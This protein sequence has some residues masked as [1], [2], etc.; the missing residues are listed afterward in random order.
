V[1]DTPYNAYW[2]SEGNSIVVVGKQ[3]LDGQLIRH[4]MLHAL[5]GAKHPRGY[6]LEKCGGVVACQ[7]DCLAEGGEAVGPPSYAPVLPSREL[8]VS[9]NVVP[10]AGAMATDSGW[11]AI[12]VSAQNP[13][14][15]AAWIN[16]V[17]VAPNENAAATFGYTFE[18]V[19]ECGGSSVY[20]YV[21]FRR[22][23]L[24]GGQ[25]IRYVF[26]KQLP[27]GRY[28]IRGFFNTDTTQISEIQIAP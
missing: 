27:A 24:A 11:I 6:F 9:L 26:D 18:C 13:S 21:N 15:T 20:Q 4:E 14:D 8:K 1:G 16:L 28:A 5:T 10:P 7:G 2:Y 23:G 25:V 12:S 19:A 17:P 22:I 3:K